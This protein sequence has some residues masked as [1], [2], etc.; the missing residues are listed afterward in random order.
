M[1]TETSKEKIYRSRQTEYRTLRRID[2]ISAKYQQEKD[3][4]EQLSGAVK[5]ATLRGDSCRT[6]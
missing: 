6:A 1:V 5:M 3:D 4:K 2:E